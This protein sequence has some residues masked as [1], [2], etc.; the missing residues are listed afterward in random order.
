MDICFHIFSIT[1]NIAMNMKVHY[2]FKTVI[3]FPLFLYSYMKLL[4]H[5]IVLC[6][7]FWEIFTLFFLVA[8]PIHIAIKGMQKLRGK[9]LDYWL[10]LVY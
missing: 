6:W 7:I 4:D 2:L 10:V 3:S 5:T 1:N 9:S 8:L